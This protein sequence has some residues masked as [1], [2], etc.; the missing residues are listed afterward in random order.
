M[1]E[2][3]LLNNLS[4][5][6]QDVIKYLL[7]SNEKI[8]AC[9]I[10]KH[11]QVSD[12]TVRNDI[13]FI[14]S[15]LENQSLIKFS[16]VNGYYIEDKISAKKVLEES[17]AKVPINVDDRVLYILKK[18]LYYKDKIDIYDLADALLISE[19]TVEKDIYRVKA[20]IHN[21][22]SNLI[23]GRSNNKIYLEGTERNKRNLL[24]K[25]ILKE[26][27]E[28]I[29][30]ILKYKEIFAHIDTKAI[31]DIINKNFMENNIVVNDLALINLLIHILIVLDKIKKSNCASID[32]DFSNLI[33]AQDI[34]ISKEICNEIKNI[35]EI[36]IP[37][38]EMNY[39]ALLI[40]GKRREADNINLKCDL[41]EHISEYILNFI[42]KIL[43]ML[44]SKYMLDLRK[45]KEFIIGM[46]IHFGN[47]YNRNLKNVSMQNPIIDLEKK[48]YP[49][50]Y[51]IGVDIANEY[52][53]YTGYFI[54][55]DE[56]GF[57]VIHLAAAIEKLDTYINTKRAA[58]VCPTGFSSSKLLKSKLDKL[59]KGRIKVVGTFSMN[60]IYKLN[61]KNID[62]L[63]STVPIDDEIPLRKIVC[64]PLL[65][66]Q[67]ME[68]I[69]MELGILEK[70]SKTWTLKNEIFHKKL[71][72]RD[73]EF[74]DRMEAIRFL[75]NKLYEQNHCA[76]D[77]V[78]YIIARE[79][80]S[81]TAYGNLLAIPHPI[82]KAAYHNKIVVGILKEPLFWGEHKVQLILLFSLSNEKEK[83]FDMV[84]EYLVSIVDSQ[85]KIKKLI[86]SR[87]IEEFKNTFIEV[88]KT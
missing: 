79:K 77:Y 87:N 64:S 51:D 41:K 28:N 15:M 32:A 42:N 24:C 78:D 71:F 10:A 31:Y 69:D 19:S 56:I 66:Y 9:D 36:N 67:D 6:Q 30:D 13:K 82:E 43:D 37:I 88:P 62:L 50:I 12:R 46:A 70:Y 38:I 11:L 52:E 55:D 49:L 3:K 35:I 25:L 8:K 61:D 18:L 5:R 21:Q 14:N 76:K 23:L 73:L 29:F 65:T 33:T 75:C 63:I 48:T 39:I 59:Y 85:E 40:A 45:D 2:V 27:K 80:L 84:F 60:E 57:I 81:S 68:K 4:N 34:E 17:R 58:V 47:L 83:D 20:I 26:Q 74:D 7:N 72:F 86:S 54:K 44:L 1:K 22:G 53:K 16:K